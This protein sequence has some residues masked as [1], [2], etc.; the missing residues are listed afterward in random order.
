MDFIGRDNEINI[1]TN[2]FISDRYEGVLVYGRKRVG[3]TEMLKEAI[4]R[5]G[6][7]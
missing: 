5:S 6:L 4:R 7:I 2:A 1:L 3:K